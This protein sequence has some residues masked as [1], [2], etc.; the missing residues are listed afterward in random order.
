M[1][2]TARSFHTYITAAGPGTSLPYLG[3]YRSITLSIALRQT[4][5]KP[6]GSR[7]NMV[8]SVCGR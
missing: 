4:E 8:Q 2:R 3:A 1:G 7:V 6:T 5:Q